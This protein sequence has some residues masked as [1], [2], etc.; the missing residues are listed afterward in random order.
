MNWPELVNQQSAAI[1]SWV[2]DILTGWPLLAVSVRR[3]HDLDKTGFV[4]L[5]W[6]IPMVGLV[7]LVWAFARAGTPGQNRFGARAAIG[8]SKA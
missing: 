3:L 4:L 1:V 5:L 2:L 7:I 8:G 6:P